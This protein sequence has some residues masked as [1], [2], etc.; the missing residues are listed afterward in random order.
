MEFQ[1]KLS[2]IGLANIIQI[3]CMGGKSGV[4]RIIHKSDKGEIFFSQGQIVYAKASFKIMLLG[5]ILESKGFLQLKD[6]E[7]ILEIQKKSGHL[8]GE[9]FIEA[10]FGTKED[11]VSSLFLQTEEIIFEILHWEDGFFDFNEDI[12]L[13][14]EIRQAIDL[15]PSMMEQNQQKIQNLLKLRNRLPSKDLI[16]RCSVDMLDKIEGIA[17]T[18]FEWEILSLVD[19][20]NSIDDIC[21][22]SN[23]TPFFA[24]KIIYDLMSYGIL[25]RTPSSAE[26]P[27]VDEFTFSM[28]QVY[29]EVHLELF[30]RFHEILG[31]QSWVFFARSFNEIK[32]KNIEVFGDVFFEADASINE[33][34]IFKNLFKL[35]DD[36]R[37][38]FLKNAL[39]NLI[40]SELLQMKNAI[41]KDFHDVIVDE[42]KEVITE[43]RS[44]YDDLF[45]EFL[46]DIESIIELVKPLPS[47]YEKGEELFKK[48]I[49]ENAKEKLLAVPKS[50]PYYKNAR[51]MIQEITIKQ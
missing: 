47:D 23:I 26:F 37:F 40:V 7:K 22:L 5:Q 27:E 41:G 2:L 14:P 29:M 10:G 11:L 19:G 48:G 36:G 8:F 32:S 9:I 42:V 12:P 20:R 13:P 51:E 38:L 31:E 17:L 4:L 34:V 33:N 43:R 18:D 35:P 15:L 24:S 30:K 45:L 3:L 44:M 49:L 25:E 50:N 28:V 16:L 6:I 1:G 39:N 46:N 21:R